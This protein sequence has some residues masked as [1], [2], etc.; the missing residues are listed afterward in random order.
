MAC[1]I[2]KNL[3]AKFAE[4]HI[5]YDF[6]YANICFLVVRLSLFVVREDVY[7]QKLF[8]APLTSYLFCLNY[9]IK[10]IVSTNLFLNRN[11]TFNSF[12]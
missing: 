8:S 12:G 1:A 9:P 11:G 5:V 6:S 3:I 7:G 10:F 2:P 4:S